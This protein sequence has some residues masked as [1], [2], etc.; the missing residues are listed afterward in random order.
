MKLC[1][2]CNIE[3]K[4]KVIASVEVDECER[5]K[6][7]WFDRDELRQLKDMTDSDLNWMDFELW[8]HK[9]DF[10]GKDSEILCPV[11]KIETR[12]IEYGNTSVQI[13]FCPSCQGVWLD[14]KEFAKIIEYLEKELDSKSF[15]DYIRES[16][17]EAR[18]IVTGHESFISEWKD[19]VTVLRMMEYRLFVEHPRL[20]DTILPIQKVNPL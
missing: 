2:K 3:L 14:E 15:S 12:I 1:P 11:C 6:G 10:V 5:C 20:L 9:D 4:P 16:I 17:K 19:F 7:I 8:K 18:E 13:A